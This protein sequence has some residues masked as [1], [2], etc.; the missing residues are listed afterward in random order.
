[1]SWSRIKSLVAKA[2]IKVF[3]FVNRARQLHARVNQAW[4]KVWN[5]RIGRSPNFAGHI[6]GVLIGYIGLALAACLPWEWL[7]IPESLKFAAIVAGSAGIVFSALF[8]AR[9]IWGF[10]DR[11][12]AEYLQTHIATFFPFLALGA[13]DESASLMPLPTTILVVWITVETVLALRWTWNTLPKGLREFIRDVAQDWVLRRQVRQWFR[14][15]VEII[16]IT[17]AVL[18]IFYNA[19]RPSEEVFMLRAGRF[20]LWAVVAWSAIWFIRWMSSC[21]SRY[22]GLDRAIME[23]FGPFGWTEAIRYPDVR[24]SVV[25]NVLPPY[26]GVMLI[27]IGAMAMQ[28]IA[29]SGISWLFPYANSVGEIAARIFAA[30]T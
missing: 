8:Q 19:H 26:L 29:V 25:A 28:R 24:L 23:T 5:L 16:G 18:L 1:M 6:S 20:T 15:T 14:F 30:L 21:Y 4:R 13:I 11:E 17:M 9:K 3:V 12:S 22:R 7:R 2:I 27:A 10:T